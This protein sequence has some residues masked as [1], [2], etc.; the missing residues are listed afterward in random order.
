MG[1]QILM[2]KCSMI[3]DEGCIVVNESRDLDN[4][5]EPFWSEIFRE[6][7]EFDMPKNWWI[8]CK[9]WNQIKWFVSSFNANKFMCLWA[10]FL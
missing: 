4:A 5:H 2:K 9:S 7:L 3:F 6:D 8:P 10:W 1:D